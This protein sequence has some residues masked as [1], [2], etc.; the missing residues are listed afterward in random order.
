MGSG[1][2]LTAFGLGEASVPPPPAKGEP[3]PDTIQGVWHVTDAEANG[4]H[5]REDVSTENVWTITADKIVIQYAD[6]H[7]D[8]W[9]YTLDPSATP[10][11]IDLKQTEGQLAGR[12]A[13]GIWE[14]KGDTLRVR[15]NGGSADNRPND[16]PISIDRSGRYFVLELV[17]PPED[18]PAGALVRLGRRELAHLDNVSCAA[19]APDGKILATGG[20]DQYVRLWDRATGRELQALRHFGL[21]RSLVWAPD[22]KTLYAASDGDGVRVWDVAT[23]KELRRL[24]DR[25]GM[26]TTLALT[27]D[28]KTLAYAVGESTVVVRDVSADKE[29]WR[30]KAGERAYHLAF[31]PDGQT[32]AVGGDLKKIHRLEVATGKELPALEGHNG[33]TY[34]VVFSPDGKVIAS[35]GSYASGEICLWDAATGGELRRWLPDIHGAVYVL[36]FAPDGKT[37]FSGHGSGPN[38]FRQWDVA[39]GR[40][41]RAFPTAPRSLMDSI[42]IVPDGKLLASGGCGGRGVYLWDVATGKEV[43]PFA[44]HHG[45][46]TA[47]AFTPD[48]KF[49]VTGSADHT[50][51]LWEADTGRLADRFRGHRGPVTAVA[52]AP[53]GKR[54]AS[55]AH[56]EKVVRLWCRATGELLRELAGEHAPFTCLAFAPDGTVLA[57]GEGMD[58]L[59][60]G[61]AAPDA[62]VRLWDASTGKAIRQL[63]GKGG[64]VSALAFSPDGQT[65]AT[66]GIDDK[67]VHLWDPH[68]GSE[69]ARLEHKTAAGAS[70][71][72]FEGTSALAF[73]PDGRTLVAVSY[74]ENKSN[75]GPA[76]PPIERDVRA[77][78]LWEVATGELRQQFTLA[79]N[80]VKSVAFADDRSLVLGCKDGTLRCL[81]L[82]TGEWQ[83]PV[84]GHR[85]AVAALALSPDGR[86]VAS[87]SGDTTTLLW[88]TAA[89]TGTH[90]QKK[91]D[92]TEREREALRNDL[93]GGDAG[94]AYRAGWELTETPEAVR[95]LEKLVRPVPDVDRARLKSLIAD[96]DSNDFA[97]REKAMAELQTCRE[98]ADPVLRDA[99]RANPSAEVRSRTERLLARRAPDETASTRVLEVLERL[100]TTEARRLL[101]TVAKGAPEARLTREATATLERLRRRP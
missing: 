8:A 19:F 79:V 21:V 22:G 80:R 49:V 94:L 100:N 26:V 57:T 91:R 18:R 88:R 35:G 36:V 11:A 89:L 90:A 55:A 45:E 72:L 99:L 48:G 39:T 32:L 34:P 74:Y 65:L 51:G 87:G 85:D 61:A 54:V 4:E 20:H 52:V 82:A 1:F 70:K 15:Y 27:T 25:K 92:R 14:R 12:T 24:G 71:W 5:Q 23:G 16:F 3:A 69:R 86:T 42:A 43:S 31:A 58:A 30:F 28:G 77:V 56:D 40:E 10:R 38:T 66:T 75:I 17:R 67:V 76:D 73:A 46:V 81:D 78:S 2:V 63:R 96:L 44:R 68:T 60:S 98:L 64:R 62:P 7:R 53:D 93:V 47:V 97:V 9:T 41:L 29:R 83:T 6:G 59:I 37:L 95:L 13:V 84:R 33:G 50:L 101:E